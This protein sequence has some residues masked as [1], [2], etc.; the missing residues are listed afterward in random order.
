MW[1]WPPQTVIQQTSPSF[2]SFRIHRI[3]STKPI[4]GTKIREKALQ[5]K[6]PNME[7]PTDKDIEIFLET[8][9]AFKTIRDKELFGEEF[10]SF[11]AYC[12]AKH[13]KTAKEINE[14]IELADQRL[15]ARN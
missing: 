8:T 4:H 14:L 9:R 12:Q 1:R 15:N 5:T 11:D 7:P 2:A 3:P 13:G 6:E 10:P